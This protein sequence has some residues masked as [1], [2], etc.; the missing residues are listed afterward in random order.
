MAIA[1][2]FLAELKDEKLWQEK[3]EATKDEQ[4][5]ILAEM[6]RQEIV[7]GETETLNF[8]FVLRN[9][10]ILKP[11]IIKLVRSNLGLLYLSITTFDC[12]DELIIK[13]KD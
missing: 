5:N 6:V 12:E 13:Y 1:S 2:R 3:F 8:F 7:A 11:Y 9:E 4:W 10:I